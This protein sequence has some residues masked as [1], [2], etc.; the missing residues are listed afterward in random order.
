MEALTLRHADII[1]ASFVYRAQGLEM[2]KVLEE[3]LARI[4]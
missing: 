2:E 1:V 4:R 3:S